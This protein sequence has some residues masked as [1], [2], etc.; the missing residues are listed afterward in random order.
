MQC[1]RALNVHQILAIDQGNCL[2]LFLL[3]FQSI[4]PVTIPTLTCV[5][6]ISSAACWISSVT[7]LDEI[8]WILKGDNSDDTSGYHNGVY[9]WTKTLILIELYQIKRLVLDIVGNSDVLYNINKIH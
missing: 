9:I 6:S 2:L 5:F 3:L 7:L 4:P 8:R 1:M